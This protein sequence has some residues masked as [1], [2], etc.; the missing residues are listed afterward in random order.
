MLVPVPSFVAWAWTLDK[1]VA[2][3]VVGSPAVM[4]IRCS[5][6]LPCWRRRVAACRLRGALQERRATYLP[7]TTAC[8]PSTFFLP[9]CR[10]ATPGRVVCGDGRQRDLARSCCLLALC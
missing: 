4:P 7:D 5:A 1:P 2:A 6:L 3:T 9:L 8:L 10:R